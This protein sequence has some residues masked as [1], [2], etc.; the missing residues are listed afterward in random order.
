MTFGVNG[1]HSAITP[2]STKVDAALIWFQSGEMCV[3]RVGVGPTPVRL[4]RR[5]GKQTEG[6]KNPPVVLF[7]NCPRFLHRFAI[8]L[9]NSIPGKWLRPR[10]ARLRCLDDSVIEDQRADSQHQQAAET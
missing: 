5:H 2:E 1:A 6:V 7:A 4:R 9:G 3:V 10:G 8:Y